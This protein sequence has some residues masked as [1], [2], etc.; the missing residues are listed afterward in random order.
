MGVRVR[1]K[2]AHACVALRQL[3]DISTGLAS[4]GTEACLHSR[5]FCARLTRLV[6]S[7]CSSDRFSSK[8]CGVARSA[9]PMAAA[10]VV[11]VFAERRRSGGLPG[12][13]KESYGS[14][15]LRAIHRTE[16]A[17]RVEVEKAERRRCL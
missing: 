15:G 4:M 1:A 6:P 5:K 16:S 3:E 14:L 17:F 10:R 2:S 7:R 11:S 12:A 8:R 9:A 13:P